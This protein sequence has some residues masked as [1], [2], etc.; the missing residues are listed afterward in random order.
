MTAPCDVTDALTLIS[1]E[2]EKKLRVE[3]RKILTS[4]NE[5]PL[6]QP[7]ANEPPSNINH[8]FMRLIDLAQTCRSSLF[9]SVF[10]LFGSTALH[11]A[12][13]H[14]QPEY[15][16]LLLARSADIAATDKYGFTVAHLLAMHGYA[17]VRGVNAREERVV[18]VFVG[19]GIDLDARDR[20]YETALSIA[21]RFGKVGLVKKLLDAPGERAGWERSAEVVVN[22]G[23]PL[24]EALQHEH[25]EVVRLLCS[26]EYR[27]R[28]LVELEDGDVYHESLEYWARAIHD[29]DEIAN[30]LGQL[31]FVRRR[32]VDA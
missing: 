27:P 25:I 4:L 5:W 24:G 7:E 3:L 16:S 6:S 14:V 22:N 11:A 9:F 13:L 31:D 21:C 2:A 28:V 15:C 10:T 12:A 26:E 18:D 8:D 32:V 1:L 20:S 30:F 17:H 19:Y 29:D 23:G